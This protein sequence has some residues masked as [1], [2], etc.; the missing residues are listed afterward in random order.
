MGRVAERAADALDQLN[1]D[2]DR[3]VR[4]HAAQAAKRVRGMK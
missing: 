1:S 2:P 3:G 4:Q